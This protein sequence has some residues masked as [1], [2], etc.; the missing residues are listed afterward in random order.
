MMH[1]L[2]NW[3]LEKRRRKKS[4]MVPME[5]IWAGEVEESGRRRG[6]CGRREREE[7][8]GQSETHR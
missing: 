4:R 8:K 3:L 2:S 6:K 1:S 7:K 5:G